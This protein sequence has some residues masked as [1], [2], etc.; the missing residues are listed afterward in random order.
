MTLSQLTTGV[1]L[2]VVVLVLIPF[3]YGLDCYVCKDCEMN[4]N[5]S[6]II[7]CQKS[8]ARCVVS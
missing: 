8:S 7:T 4:F 6:Q 2:G 5:S 1:L 3:S